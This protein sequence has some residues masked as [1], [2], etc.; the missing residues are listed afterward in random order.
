MYT[1][2]KVSNFQERFTELVAE[3]GKSL[4]KLSKELHISNQTLSAWRAGTRSPKP[5]TVTAV[6]NYFNVSFKWLY[7]FDV[8]KNVFNPN[9]ILNKDSDLIKK[10]IINMS[11]DDFTL[12]QSIFE[13]TEIAMRE[14]G[15]L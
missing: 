12:V 13:K 10:V 2:L 6:A 9:N 8:E 14:R 5:P 15:E 3:S 7:G 4:L 11:P 1:G